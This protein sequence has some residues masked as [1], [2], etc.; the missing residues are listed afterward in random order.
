MST[1]GK[2]LFWDTF[3]MNTSNSI[4]GHPTINVRGPSYL[5]LT[6]SVSLRRQDISS[7]D[8]DYIEYVGR[9]L[10]WGRILSTCVISMWRNDIKYKY[11]YS[12]WKI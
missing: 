7:H 8:I 10:I 11:M 1:Q 2:E 5:G 6:R 3:L 12:L 9:Y 4:A